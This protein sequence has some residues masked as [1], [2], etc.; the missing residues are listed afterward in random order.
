MAV[1]INQ[2]DRAQQFE[3]LAE[4]IDRQQTE[5][6]FVL[7]NDGDSHLE[8]Y[9]RAKGLPVRRIRYRR[10]LD[11]PR[12]LVELVGHWLRYRPDRVHTHL[13]IASLIGL[14]AAWLLRLPRL[15]T[16]H[17]STLHHDYH[18]H[19]RWRDRLI[20]RLSQQIV[21]I[22]PAVRQVLV[23]REGVS[24]AKIILIPHG[25][26]LAAFARPDPARVA[27][28]AQKYNPA[29]QRP[30][31]GLVSRFTAWKGVQDAIDA[32]PRV[33]DVYPDALLLLA[34]A[35]GDAEAEI[36]ARLDELPAGSWGAIRFE[37][38]IQSFYPLLDVFVHVPVDAWCEAFGQT[39]VEAA[40]AGIPMVCTLSGIAPEFVRH[41]VNAWVVPY[42]SP[43]AIAEGI[44]TL[45]GA[46]E[47]GQALA[48]QARAD[49]Q[50]FDFGPFAEAHARLYRI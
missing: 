35:R 7:L 11:L 28:L 33:L 10:P 38:D 3:W 24:P 20:N 47:Q 1:V 46:P 30:V 39:Y 42:R 44:L 9:L 5:L 36:L 8:R 6:R 17:H 48:A 34:N 49:V 26:Q 31:V 27:A 15:H 4:S 18:P 22:S 25:F 50:R 12:C 37:P 23:E 45:L 14:L 13:H 32:W 29:G 2:I 43:A 41:R 21:A 19:A 40:A 16:R